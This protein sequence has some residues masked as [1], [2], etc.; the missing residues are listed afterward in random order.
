MPNTRGNVDYFKRIDS[1]ARTKLTHTAQK[2][3][4]RGYFD[5]DDHGIIPWTEPIAF[6]AK[7][8][9][10][11]GGCY[12]I[13]AIGE[14]FRAYLEAL[15]AYIHPESSLAGAWIG[16]IEGVGG[17]KP[18]DLPVH[19]YPLHKK[20]NLVQPG[21]G[22]MNHLGPDMRIG[23]ELGWGGL[24]ENI[25]HY[26]RRNRPADT[27]FYDGH[28]EFVLGVRGWVARLAAKAREMASQEMD[29]GI[30]ANLLSMADMNEWLV[31]HAPRTLR[32]ACQFLAHF[33]TLDRTWCCGGALGQLDELLRP[34]YEA[35]Q[36]AGLENDDAVIW[37]ITSLF[38]NDT[39]YS[40]I[41]GPGPDGGD[42]TSPVSYLVLE[43]SHRLGIPS[44]LAVRVHEKLEPALLRK[45]V[46]NLLRDGTGASYACSGGLDAGFARNGF[47]LGLARMR[48]KVGCN[49]T[50]LPGIE[51]CHQDVT[52]ICMIAPFLLAFDELAGDA[53]A[54]KSM[55]RLWQRFA[56]ELDKSVDVTKEGFD[57]HMAHQAGNSPEIVLNLFCHG[58]IERGLDAA[59]GGVDIYNF[60]CDG[61]GLAT[62]ADSLAAIEQRVVREK[63]LGWEELKKILDAN[64]EGAQDVRRMLKNI[65]RYGSGNSRADYWAKRV[66][67]L[68]TGLV[69][70]SPTPRGYNAIP[71]L[72]SHGVIAMLGQA[73]G[74]TPNGRLAHEPIS[75]SADPDPG[76]APHSGAAPTAKAN[77]VAMV[78]PGWGNTT[79]LQID[80]DANLLAE[81][82]GVE[83]IEALIL[84]HD[85]QGGT[86]VNINVISRQ[87]ILEAHADP[88]KY[89][90][91][92]VRVTGF[93]AYFQ[94][95]SP[96]YRLQIVQ[97]VLS[98]Q[99]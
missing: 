37:H 34:Y 41:G 76:Y 60:C 53:Q 73:L 21:I 45:S 99:K 29:A 52:R 58:P 7:P 1:L 28:E 36:A 8:N 15:P 82:G 4:I 66:A 57:W 33:Q 19:L 72:F 40:Q 51:Y 25:R 54:E 39:H 18:Q 11:S 49:W 56:E 35:D 47:P 96:D 64:F 32:E 92:V 68:F 77:A 83:A 6:R 30:R 50:A 3:K 12:G 80:I 84:G 86:L 90:D 27:A 46:E 81:H 74:A 43:A 17:W 22:G 42:L 78:Q 95:L 62:V 98:A 79:P 9:H 44:N 71:G 85:R 89:P 59:A 48:A 70:G 31:D 67:D 75:H 20:Y 16:G 24:L 63:R 38:F 55:E 69:K 26:R 10:P 23:L 61:V 87:K 93:S 91:L 2:F 14:N 88:S 65:P 94:S 97:R 5:N 13:R